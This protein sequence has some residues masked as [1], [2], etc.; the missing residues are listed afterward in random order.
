MEH[1]ATFICPEGVYTLTDEHKPPLGPAPWHPAKVS[2]VTVRFS[3]QKQ[4]GPPGL[5]HLLGGNKD[6]KKDKITTPRDREDAAS[7]SSSEAPDD[8]DHSTQDHA[9]T[10]TSSL[11]Q[12]ARNLFSHPAA[13][14]RKNDAHPKHNMRTTSSTFITR[15]QTTE[16]LTKILQSKQG[17]TTFLF[18]NLAKTCLWVEAGSKA[19]VHIPNPFFS[20]VGNL[21]YI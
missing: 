11:T 21:F 2:T 16:G 15:L 8:V 5:A 1:E 3:T 14:K 19:K 6:A 9:P 20:K 10:A 4:G 18:Y 12:D 7:A 13:G 17:D